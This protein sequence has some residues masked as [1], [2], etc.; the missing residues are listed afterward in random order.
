MLLA[1]KQAI[2]MSPLILPTRYRGDRKRVAVWRICKPEERANHAS[3]RYHPT[4][5]A[6]ARERQHEDLHRFKSTRDGTVSQLWESFRGS[7][8]LASLDISEAISAET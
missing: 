4:N 7:Q 3:I 2:L 8:C 6:R 1:L 5:N